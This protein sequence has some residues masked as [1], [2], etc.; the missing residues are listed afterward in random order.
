M[1][2]YPNAYTRGTSIPEVDL[3]DTKESL[4]INKQYAYRFYIDD[5]DN[6]QDK[7]SVAIEY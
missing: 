5:F 1:P 2:E 6:I 7:Y 4:V 3:T